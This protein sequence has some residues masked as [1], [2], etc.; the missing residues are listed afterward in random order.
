MTYVGSSWLHVGSLG[1][2]FFGLGGAA[3]GAGGTNVP[4]LVPV[5]VGWVLNPPVG[6][7]CS[8]GYVVSGS[9]EVVSL[10]SRWEVPSCAG[11]VVPDGDR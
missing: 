7:G 9:D 10:V 8:F 5:V 11:G 4:S 1:P 2:G 6:P 3:G